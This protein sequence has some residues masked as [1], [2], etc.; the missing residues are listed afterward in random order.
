SSL[1]GARPRA[2]CS[3]SLMRILRERVRRELV[4]P[5]ALLRL[6]VDEGACDRE[7]ITEADIIDKA[8][9]VCIRPATLRSPDHE[10]GQGRKLVKIDFLRQPPA[11]ALRLLLDHGTSRS[12][13]YGGGI[14]P[15]NNDAVSAL[16]RVDL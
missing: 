2:A 15:V 10:L 4:T 13:V 1:G 12:D 7:L 5:S 11:S 8:G 6:A 9:H 3:L 14:V 16:D